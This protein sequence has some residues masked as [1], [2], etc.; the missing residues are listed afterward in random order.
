MGRKN[1]AKTILFTSHLTIGINCVIV[2]L[3]REK[4]THSQQTLHHKRLSSKYS[5][6]TPCINQSSL[7]NTN[8]KKLLSITIKW[9]FPRRMY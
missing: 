4:T 6:Y 9:C 1:A 5:F 7:N 3:K 8:K 2:T